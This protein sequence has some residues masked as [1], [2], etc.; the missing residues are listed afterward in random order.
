LNAQL[1]LSNPAFNRHVNALTSAYGKV[2]GHATATHT[3]QSQ[4]YKQLGT[5]AQVQGYEDVYRRLCWMT[6]S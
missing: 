2:V 6:F 3:A 4:I 1:N 5:Q